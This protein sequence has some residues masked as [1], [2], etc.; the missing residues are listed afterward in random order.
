MN[1]SVYRQRGGWATGV[2][3]GVGR[4]SGAAVPVAVAALLLPL[5][6]VATATLCAALFGYVVFA[7]T[8]KV[9]AK[10]VNRI[11]DRRGEDAVDEAA[12]AEQHPHPRVILP[13]RS[14]QPIAEVMLAEFA[15]AA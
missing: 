3:G 2:G 9:S 10:A 1:A 14:S 8:W 15:T 12:G 7:V 11:T 5:A 13:R 4:R 6:A